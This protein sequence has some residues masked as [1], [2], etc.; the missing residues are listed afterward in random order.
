[1]AFK[2]EVLMV[3]EKTFIDELIVVKPNIF[4][5]N[6]GYFFE[7]FKKEKYKEIGIDVEFIQDNISKSTYGTVRGLHY[8]VGQFAQ[9]KLCQVIYGKVLDFAVDIR[10]GSPTFGKYFAIE[11][12]D[13]NNYQFF[14]PKGFAHG[15]SVLS[16]TAIFH[17]KVSNYYNKE[18]ER[19]INFNDETLNIDWKIENPIVS[20]KDLQAEKLNNINQDFI[21]VKKRKK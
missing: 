3:F 2:Q 20:D 1:M 13:E 12:S 10:F 4:R 15:F 5:D 18:S 11:L 14:I 17:Y 6:R 16:E 9:D 19:T 21:Y 8:Q 7:S